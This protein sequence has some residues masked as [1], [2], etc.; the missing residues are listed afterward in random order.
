MNM[1]EASSGEEIDTRA[2]E[3]VLRHR[4][5]EGWSRDDQD[6]LETWLDESFAHR[7]AYW[8]LEATWDRA[9]RLSALK[10]LSLQ[11]PAPNGKSRISWKIAAAAFALAAIVSAA[12]VGTTDERQAVYSTPLGGHSTIALDD[13]SRVELNTNTELHMRS[14]KGER[15]VRLIRGEAF[16]KI[17]HDMSRPFVVLAGG[18]R[19]TDLGTQFLVRENAGGIKVAV[20]EGRAR[21]D[22]EAASQRRKILVLLP[23]DEAVATNN[24]LSV[25]R[26][27]IREADDE[28]GWRNGVLVFRH[29]ALADVAAEYN[30]YN[31][32]K[33]VIAPSVASTTIS[34][35]LPAT[36]VG[37]FA[38][39]AQNFLGLHVAKYGGE[40]VI[41]R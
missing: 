12:L 22:S 10:R 2:A 19:I 23:G 33:I 39:M 38:R 9:D 34:A 25:T 32:N 41:S 29:T 27:T 24:G 11:R 5:L 16:F 18:A 3:F 26:R 20:M 13:G 15:L 7:T 36:D 35:T 28:L 4:D 40:I 17:R 14:T 8:R 21:L 31:S 1:P 30:R 37:A 6:V